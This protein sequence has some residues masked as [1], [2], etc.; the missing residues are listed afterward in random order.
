MRILHIGSGFRP[1][2]RGGLVTYV[3]DLMDAQVHHG[4][5]VSYLFSGRQYPW[6]RRPRLRRWKRGGVS[7]LE[8][9]NSP[10]FDHGRQPELELAEPQ[11]ERILAAVIRDVRPDI[12][13]IQ[14][15]AG[16]PSSVLEVVRACG[17]PTV[18]TLQ[19]YFA[20]CPTFKLLD[21]DGQVCLRTQI[22][23]DCVATTAA[24]PRDS[25]ILF[26]ATIRSDLSQSRLMQHVG[27]PRRNRLIERYAK[28]GAARA[29]V[30]R[31]Q[32][33]VAEGGDLAPAFQRRREVNVARLNRVDCLIAMSSR[34]AEIYA[35]L[36]VAPERLRVLQLTLAHLE[37][38]TP[39]RREPQ[40]LIMFATLAS[41][42][43]RAKGG[44]LLLDA[45]R[46]LASLVDPRCFRV[47]VFGSCEPDF[48]REAETVPEIEVVGP[49]LP[50]QLDGL[51]D[52]IDVGLMTS[53]WEEAYGY[54]GLEFLAKGIPVI[55]NAIGGMPAYTREGQTGWLNHSCSA[56]ELAQIMLDVIER[57]DQISRLNARIRASRHSIIK[58]MSRH[59]NEMDAVYMETLEQQTAAYD[60]P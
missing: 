10:L 19:D 23:A 17:V 53:I 51:L 47:R 45:V 57:P 24:D 16:L 49:Y 1:W 2:R 37:H 11:I 40:R 9:I 41:F 8:I 22:G 54:A 15:L 34:V 12:V 35:Q 36:G 30:D 59:V 4:H 29:P 28:A 33:T 55:A 20:L 60:S 58:P 44:H 46:Q 5:E 14:E 26:D 18:M 39:R 25:A 27:Q 42:E 32:L 50:G 52:G 13:H 3:E 31:G 48:A 56:G 21:A 43:S 6:L 38:L 7:M